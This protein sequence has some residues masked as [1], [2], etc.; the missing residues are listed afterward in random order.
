MSDLTLYL[1][2]KNFTYGQFRA[3]VGVKDNTLRTWLKRHFPDV[4]EKTETGRM[5]FSG[6]EVLY[7]KVFAQLITR[8]S[9]STETAKAISLECLL[10]VT[11][12]TLS[13]TSGEVKIGDWEPMYLLVFGVSERVDIKPITHSKL[14]EFVTSGYLKPYLIV[15]VD[16]FFAATQDQLFTMLEYNKAEE[17]MKKM[18]QPMSVGELKKRY[19]KSFGKNED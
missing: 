2:E 12:L 8:F 18:M 6:V 19:E 11:K 15:P 9:M 17:R 3:L 1:G 10:R 16:S 14:C 7:I 13:I 5:L 4:G